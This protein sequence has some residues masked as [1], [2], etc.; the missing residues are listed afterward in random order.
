MPGGSMPRADPEALAFLRAI[1]P[2]DPRIHLRPMFG[3][4]AAFVNGTMFAGVFGEDVFLRLPEHDREA[5]AAEGGGPFAPMPDRPM[6]EYTTLPLA[7][8]DDP[9][10]AATWLTRALTW[11]AALPA[12]PPSRRSARQ[13]PT[14]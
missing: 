7:W 2:D 3:N 6:K 5:L 9:E 4:H 13:P 1:L 12:K 8:R 11:T 10:T 14:P